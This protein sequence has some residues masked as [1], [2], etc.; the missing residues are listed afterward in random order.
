LIHAIYGGLYG[1]R[2]SVLDGHRKTG[3]LMPVMT[4][5][6][7]AA[8][9]GLVRYESRVF[10][11]DY[12]DD[13]FA[14]LF[15]M[16]KVTRH[17]LI[18][19][20]ASFRTV[21]SDFV[22]SDST[23]FHP[24]DVLED[25]DGSLIIVDTG[26]WYKLCCPTSQL[27][28]PDVLGGIYRVRREGSSRVGD[29]R[30]DSIPWS[31]QTPAR[32]VEHLA[33]VRPAVQRRAIQEL[34]ERGS[35]AVATLAQQLKQSSVMDV[36]RLSIW[37][38]T[39]IEGEAARRAVRIGLGDSDETVRQAAI[40]SVGVWRDAA[41][42]SALEDILKGKSDPNIR[43]AAEVLGRIGSRRSVPSLFAAVTAERLQDRALDHS[44]LYALME[45]ADVEQ[46]R[47]FL[48][49]TDP[50]VRRAALIVMDQL[51]GRW[52]ES[53]ALLSAG[54]VAPLLGGRNKVLRET[55]SWVVGHHPEWG[56]SLAGV[57]RERLAA[58]KLTAAAREELRL[59]LAQH[60]RGPAVQQLMVSALGHDGGS[61]EMRRLVLRAMA[62]AGLKPA[63]AAWLDAVT[64]VLA[65]HDAG[66]VKE[67]VA[68]AGALM[69][70][71]GGHAGLSN[72]LI[73]VGRELK[74]GS[75]TRLAALA[76]IR[77]GLGVVEPAQ[78]E[79][80]VAHLGPSTSVSS[81]GAAVR[82]LTGAKLNRDQ[83]W[84]LAGLLPRIGPLELPKVLVLFERGGDEAMGM[85]LVSVLGDSLNSGLRAEQVKR[86]LD[87][88]PPTV[89]ERGE[90]LMHRL[91]ADAAKQQAHLE[92]LIKEIHE[93]GG[94]EVRRGQGVFNSAKAACSACHAIGYLG[95]R[96]GPDLTHIGRVRTERDL[97]E[98]IIYP[99]VSFVRSYEPM[100]VMTQSGDELSGV[101][102]S[103]GVEEVVLATGPTSEV[104]IPRS[105]V[106]EM[107][108][109]TI[110][111]MPQGLHQQLSRQELADLIAFLKG[112]K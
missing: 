51:A 103:D 59:Q 16:H 30:G 75:E 79:L 26:G 2:H 93:V 90:D 11:Q 80:L 61:N 14:C 83:L 38:L 33:D 1:K 65:E 9:C 53:E 112:A 88:Y 92:E 91:N 81:R 104:K 84:A 20:G 101:L 63:P 15:N 37:A 102:R 45:I 94:G 110:S 67:A 17:H 95:G 86:V 55:A 23:D 77:G 76:S 106:V 69:L 44:L 49:S 96:L 56:E 24:T 50:F 8:P 85:R 109:G 66:I 48:G 32:L 19:S 98:A 4:H 54:E 100:T 82:A 107:R 105:E 39:R 52:P 40:H 68:T 42:A 99:S 18:P 5:L 13:L 111:V 25:A 27:A 34:V 97:L 10:G 64:V 36:R 35:E 12:Q 29:P 28:K 108:P 70:P 46:T 22:I 72:A 89:Q 7:A 47:S 41:A 3:D 21:D 58:G 78:F 57:F 31:R 62:G 73:Q 60:S 71:K 43:A 74:L 6:G 87:R